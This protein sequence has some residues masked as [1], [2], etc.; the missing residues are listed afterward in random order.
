MIIQRLFSSKAQ[1]VFARRD[2][3]GLDE[4]AK[5]QLKSARSIA[6]SHLNNVRRSNNIGF[7]RNDGMKRFLRNN[8]HRNA[9]S[10]FNNG[11]LKEEKEK[12]L[13][14]SKKRNLIKKLG[15][16]ALVTGGVVAAG[17]GAKK[18][19]DKKKA[20]KDSKEKES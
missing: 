1:K 6:A 4:K 19:I 7:D 13:K 10:E 5:K 3:E 17:I 8:A 9:I 11:F 16:G 18:V 2:Y 14:E 12:L 15:K 20:K